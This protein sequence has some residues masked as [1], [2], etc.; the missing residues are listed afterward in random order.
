MTRYYALVL[1]PGDAD[2]PEEEACEA[3]AKLLY[4]FMRSEVDL[5]G[6]SCRT[7]RGG[8]PEHARS[9]GSTRNVSRCGTCFMYRKPMRS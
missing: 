7:T 9:L 8:W 1:V 2:T 5:G 3:A 6:G 4:P